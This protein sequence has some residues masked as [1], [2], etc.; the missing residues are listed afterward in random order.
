MNKIIF[1]IILSIFLNC[2]NGVAE[3]NQKRYYKTIRNYAEIIDCNVFDVDY[4]KSKI[5]KSKKQYSLNVENLND[6]REICKLYK[7]NIKIIFDGNDTNCYYRFCDSTMILNISENEN[8]YLLSR[9]FCHELAHAIQ[10]KN[11]NTEIITKQILPFG[12]LL[13]FELSAERTAYFVLE[14]YFSEYNK[15]YLNLTLESFS[16]YSD[17]KSQKELYNFYNSRILENYDDFFESPYK[18]LYGV[19]NE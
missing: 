4:L 15:K 13:A 17:F 1:I 14:E 8:A 16:M 12:I 11:C 10:D 6:L 7:I 2:N 19:N 18:K 5:I 9:K 3:N